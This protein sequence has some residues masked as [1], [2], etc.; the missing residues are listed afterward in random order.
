MVGE[1]PTSM[2]CLPPLEMGIHWFSTLCRLVHV[3][4]WCMRFIGNL[5]G[6]QQRGS[7][8]ATELDM[9][10]M[11]WLKHVQAKHFS[12]TDEKTKNLMRQLNVSID[13]T[14][15]MRCYGRICNAELPTSTVNPI[16]LPRDDYFTELIIRDTHTDTL[17]AGT[18]QTLSSI[19]QSYWIPQG[20]VTVRKILKRCAIC[21][22]IEGGP[23]KTPRFPDFPAERVRK[24][25]PFSYSGMDYFD[26]LYV[27]NHDDI[28]KVWISLFTCMSVRA[29]H[30]EVARDMTAEQFLHCFRRSTAHRGTLKMM[31]SDNTPH[32]KL[33]DKT[34][35]QAIHEVLASESVQT[36]A[37][38]HNIVWRFAVE[39]A[40]WMRGFYKRLIGI[41]KRSIKKSIGRACL[42]LGQLYTIITEVEAVINEQPLVYVGDEFTLSVVLT[43]ADFLSLNTATGPPHL[44]TEDNDPEYTDNTTS[45]DKLL[46]SWKKGLSHIDRLWKIWSDEYL[47]HLREC[48]QQNHR[49]P[50]VKSAIQPTVGEVV[51]LKENAPRGTWKLAV[52]T[53]LIPSEDGNIRLAR[54][55]TQ[56]LTSP[57]VMNIEMIIM[58]RKQETLTVMNTN[59]LT[60]KEG[61]LLRHRNLW[62]NG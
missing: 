25:K 44:N 59:K 19:R 56:S 40:P 4:S 43:P 62:I 53:E 50:R 5:K 46:S 22:K 51:L 26:P 7:L 33:A 31:Y 10:K 30:I 45:T 14:G 12:G 2:E 21:K 8:T 11:Q 37:A 1:G 23:S 18:S 49:S 38:N 16:L 15:H 58:E 52:I 6:E 54:V 47:L 20:R 61:L 48:Y 41:M 29:V 39:L 24:S 35:E 27:R 3:T 32:F 36:Y 42:S 60:P 28:V 34:L 9:A 57:R 17:H 55:H 13:E